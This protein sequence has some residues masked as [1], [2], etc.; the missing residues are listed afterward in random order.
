MAG[1]GKVLAVGA[2]AFVA[3]AV[4]TYVV[5]SSLV[6]EGSAPAPSSAVGH[7]D[8][9]PRHGGLV[10]MNSDTHFE[11]VL[12]GEGR[13]SVYFSDAVRAP[14]PASTAT[15]VGVA[16]APPGR[17]PEMIPLQIDARG[18]SWTG[19]SARIAD[20]NAIVRIGYTAAD[21]PY[22]IDVPA[23]AWPGLTASPRP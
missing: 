9:R 11:V 7:F 23:S 3:V 2:V 12:D 21:K 17:S 14:L 20:P 13:S 5:H 19:R 1:L 4:R 16:V 6:D 10:L 18:E 15:E 22:W 8:H